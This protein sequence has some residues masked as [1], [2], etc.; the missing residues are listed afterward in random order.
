MPTYGTED[1]FG[2]PAWKC[3]LGSVFGPVFVAVLYLAY[4]HNGSLG[5]W[6]DRC[7]EAGGVPS[8]DVFSWVLILMLYIYLL[9]D[10]VFIPDLR[11]ELQAHHVMAIVA[12]FLSHKMFWGGFPFFI[13]GAAIM[14][15]GS[16]SMNAFA[17]NSSSTD[18]L[19]LYVVIMT[20]SN[21]LTAPLVWRW[22]KLPEL[23]SL[24]RYFWFFGSFILLY[25]RQKTAYDLYLEMG[26]DPH[27]AVN[28]S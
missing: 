17:L 15:A 10:M 16:A 1:N 14:E 12:N 23:P 18:A 7:V 21:G 2:G 11:F 4:A 3:A 22:S 5:E 13:T 20:I 25:M 19:M 27:H 28:H 6:R 8:D 24:F 9:A 26:S